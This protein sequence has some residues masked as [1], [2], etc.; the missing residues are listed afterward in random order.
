MNNQMTIVRL[1]S[2]AILVISCLT[3][4]HNSNSFD[5]KKRI[6]FIAIGMVKWKMEKEKPKISFL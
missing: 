6:I 3:I 5:S 1:V 4:Y 2:L